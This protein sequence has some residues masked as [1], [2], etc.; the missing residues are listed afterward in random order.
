[1]I[2]ENSSQVY[3]PST[4]RNLLREPVSEER[5]G[6]AGILE[7]RY[8][9]KIGE[10]IAEFRVFAPNGTSQLS[11]PIDAQD[12]SLLNA[13]VNGQANELQIEQRTDRIVFLPDMAGE[14]SLLLRFLPTVETDENAV[15]RLRALCLRFLPQAYESPYRRI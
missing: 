8:E 11:I 7:A 14:H 9:I 10:L 12:L 2:P 15:T 13:Q 4:L 1:M 3:V 5:L 6:S